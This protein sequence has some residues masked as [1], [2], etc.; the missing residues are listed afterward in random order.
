VVKSR[1]SQD[2]CRAMAEDKG[3]RFYMRHDFSE[4]A[5]MLLFLK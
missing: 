2:E 5:Y 3:F 4:M 1:I